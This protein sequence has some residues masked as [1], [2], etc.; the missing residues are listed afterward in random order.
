MLVFLC[1]V[2]PTVCMDV[3]YLGMCVPKVQGY[4]PSALHRG[5]IHLLYPV[6]LCR[7]SI[8]IQHM[9]YSTQNV[10]GDLHLHLLSTKLKHLRICT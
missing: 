7:C 8:S 4:A 2:V 3:P 1:A 9:V 10:P 6:G 5:Y